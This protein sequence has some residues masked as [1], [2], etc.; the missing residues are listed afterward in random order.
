MNIMGTYSGMDMAMV[1]QLINAEKSKGIKF[2]QKKEEY[3]QSKNAWK[4]LNTR[5]DSLYKRADDLQKTDTYDSK[6][7]KLSNNNNLSVSASSKAA[8][9][10]YRV[11]VSKLATQAQL[12]GAKVSTDSIYTELNTSGTLEF[13][14]GGEGLTVEV[15]ETDSLLD[16]SD[17]IN[18]Q[19]K[20]T[21]IR[22]SIVDNRLILTNNEFGIKPLAVTGQETLV[23]KLGLSTA[24][25]KDGQNAEFSVNGLD[26]EP[27]STNTIDDVIEGL[28]FNLT[29]IHEGTDTTIVTVSE[30]MD[31]AADTLQK[32]V[33]QY[34]STQKFISTQL[35]VGDPSADD[36]KTGTLSGDGTVMRLQSNLRRMM[37][38]VVPGDSA[39]RSLKDL[40]VEVDREGNATF[41]RKKLEEQIKADPNAVSDFFSKTETIPEKTVGD[42]VIPETEKVAFAK[43]IRGFVNEYI[44]SSSGIIKTRNDTYDRMIKDV[45][46]RISTFEDRLEVKKQR[47]IKQFTALDTA[48][49][50]AESQLEQMY[51]QLGMGQE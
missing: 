50:Q 4:D 40:G 8:T 36:N 6:S 31:K 1:E 7:V 38:K 16:I 19:A 2:T 5:L 3:T 39:V 35:D 15:K 13:N 29:N 14:G 21:G 25:L 49:M 24:T 48:M 33:D 9:G 26:I 43:D 18:S 27:R 20:E 23:T 12:T 30:N 34:N 44:S 51:S 28:T 46:D 47:Y 41:D 17:K 22:S 42:K 45:N 10:E 37:S 32:F 11:Q